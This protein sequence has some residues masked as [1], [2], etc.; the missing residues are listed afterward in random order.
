MFLAFGDA[1]CPT[2]PDVLCLALPFQVC[3]LQLSKRMPARKLQSGMW[4]SN[5]GAWGCEAGVVLV[6]TFYCMVTETPL[7][8]VRIDPDRRSD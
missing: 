5:V 6:D 7:S 3:K 1:S 2:E 8:S 4:V